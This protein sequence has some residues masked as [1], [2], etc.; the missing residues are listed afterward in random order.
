MRFFRTPAILPIIYPSLLWKINTAGK[1]LYLTFDDGPVPGPTEFVLETLKA[2]NINATFFCIGDNVR[3]NPDIFKKVVDA[4]HVIAN[5][6]FDHMNGW[7]A[8][9]SE[10]VRNTELCQTLLPKKRLFRPPFGRI[11][12]SQISSLSDYKIVMWDVLTFDYDRS[13]DSE[14]CLRGS[15]KAVRPGSI[16]VFHDSVKAEK[17][18]TYVL[19]R[20]IDSCLSN[21]YSFHVL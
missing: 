17:N 10:Y 6:T 21:G 19:P 18:V 1:D 12:R 13:L 15:L 8:S 14:K 11:T 7:K 2:S 20:F 9:A 3:K 16:I 4:R 5:H